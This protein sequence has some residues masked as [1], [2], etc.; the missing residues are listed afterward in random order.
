MLVA[1][2]SGGGSRALQAEDSVPIEHMEASTVWILVAGEGIGGGSGFVVGDQR[3]VATNWHVVDDADRIAV[4]AGNVEGAIEASIV[5]GSAATDLAILE[6]GQPLDRPV[7]EFV[8][9][10]YVRKAQDVYAMGFPGAGMDEEATD[11]D[12]S[13]TEVKV[14]RGIISGF[15]E[16]PSG[17]SLYQ[18]DAALNPG[19]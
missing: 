9:S 12:T 19:N 7:V 5:W 11:L 14:T 2:L 16:S 8:Q 4:I 10:R 1:L 18:V 3:H 13:A 6:L 17:T 15:V